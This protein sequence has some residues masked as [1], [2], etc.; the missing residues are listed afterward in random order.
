MKV[1]KKSGHDM[2]LLIV[3]GVEWVTVISVLNLNSIHFVSLH[4]KNGSNR[5][6]SVSLHH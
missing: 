6:W 4:T 3:V 5:R 1:K 2:T